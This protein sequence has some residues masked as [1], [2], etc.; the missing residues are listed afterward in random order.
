[1]ADGQVGFHDPKRVVTVPHVER[2]REIVNR[3]NKTKIFEE[4]H[5][6]DL[7]AEREEF[8]RKL[9]AIKKEHARQEA[10]EKQKAREEMEK[11]KHERDYARIFES[12]A[13]GNVSGIQSTSDAKAALKFE[14]D[15]M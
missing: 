14:D 11:M 10:K 7:L 2:D 3:L 6:S 5:E 4:K 9:N 13:T 12:G 1:M 15:F 8:D